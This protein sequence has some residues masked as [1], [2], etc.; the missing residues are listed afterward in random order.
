M[1]DRI[2]RFARAIATLVTFTYGDGTS[3]PP[4]HPEALLNAARKVVKSID[5]NGGFGARQVTMKMFDEVVLEYTR[6]VTIWPD[7]VSE[8]RVEYYATGEGCVIVQQP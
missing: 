4:R 3:W 6:S 8:L 5:K 2:E 7:G 1:E